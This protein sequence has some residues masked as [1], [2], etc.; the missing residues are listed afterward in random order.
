MF[1]GEESWSYA[2]ATEAAPSLSLAMPLD[3]MPMMISVAIC[4][5]APL[6]SP[7]ARLQKSTGTRSRYCWPASTYA[8][9]PVQYVWGPGRHLSFWKFDKRETLKS[10]DRRWLMTATSSIG[11]RATP[12]FHLLRLFFSFRV[13]FCCVVG[14]LLWAPRSTLT[15]TPE[16]CQSE[17]TL[18]W[19]P[20]LCS[21]EIK[22]TVRRL[23]LVVR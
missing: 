3:M 17:G 13:E 23:D 15:I 2:T 9:L 14:R 19:R 11:F 7:G 18:R 6:S 12:R 21:A 8:S 10:S 16:A 5:C 22:N 20:V 4:L 1:F